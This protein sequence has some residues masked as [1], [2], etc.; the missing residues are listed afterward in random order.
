[1]II[2]L[3]SKNQV[4]IDALAE[5]IKDYQFLQHSTIVP[6][7]A[8]SRVYR[9]PM[10]IEETII[11]AKNRAK[12][13][14]KDCNLSF[15]IESGLIAIP[16]T[17]TGY[18]DICACVVYDGHNQSTGL[19]CAFE[20]PPQVTKELLENGADINEAFYKCGYTSNPK[21]GSAEGAIGMLTNGRITRKE[22]TK[23]AIQMALIQLENY[24]LYLKGNF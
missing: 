4:K 1:M 9:Q 2:N 3:G 5:I 20:L 16:H 12:G 7:D 22:Y 15:G 21:L 11:G 19:S 10:C 24:H 14:F 23:Q 8:P 13:A 6:L 18:M 17:N